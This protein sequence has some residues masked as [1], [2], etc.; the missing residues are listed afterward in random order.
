MLLVNRTSRNARCITGHFNVNIN[1][2]NEHVREIRVSDAL[3]VDF[4]RAIT[5]AVKIIPGFG[6]F[7]Y[8]L[9]LVCG[10]CFMSAGFQNGLN[11]YILPSAECDLRLTSQQ[12]G[13]LNAVFLAG[14]VLSAYVW[15]SLADSIGRKKVL[16]STLMFDSIITFLSSFAQEFNVIAVCRFFNGFIVGAPSCLVF[17]Y[18]GEF[19]STKTSSASLCFVGFFWTLSWMLLPALAWLVIPIPWSYHSAYFTYNS[20]RLFVAFISIPSL[21]SATLL[22]VFYPESPKF[23]LASGRTSQALDVLQNMYA[24]NTG[25]RPSQYEVRYLKAPCSPSSDGSGLLFLLKAMWRQ[26]KLLF[27]PPLLV[28]TLLC[29]A[30][31]FTNMFGYFGLGLWLPEIFNRFEAFYSSHPNETVSVCELTNVS[32]KQADISKLS[33]CSTRS[34]DERVFINTMIIGAVCLLGNITSGLLAGHLQRNI[35]PVATMLIAGVSAAT[36][37]FLRSSLQNL[38]ISCI[39]LSAISTGNFV[40]TSVVVDIF[41]TSIRAMAVCTAILAGR[42]GA[43]VSNLLLGHL[44]DISCEVPMFLLGSTVMCG[45]GAQGQ[46]EED[47]PPSMSPGLARTAPV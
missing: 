34:V 44:L 12:K 14:S 35:M 1:T 20:W 7:H 42:V 25:R 40:L 29:S 18:L 10:V 8:G 28:R 32:K 31:L 5:L 15:G 23:L 13:T 30:L 47:F 43:I 46:N 21:M 45:L 9:I 24:T 11:A 19:H 3:P 38:I 39:F 4:E 37:Y 6:R 16:V 41:P 17:P 33:D 2:N 36:I 27:V 26:I 22:L